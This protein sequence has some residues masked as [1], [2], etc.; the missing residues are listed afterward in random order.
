MT[1]IVQ[2]GVTTFGQGDDIS[3][4]LTFSHPNAG[5]NNRILWCGVNIS[6]SSDVTFTATYAGELLQVGSVQR[7][8]N[9]NLMQ[10]IWTL[11]EQELGFAGPGTHDIVISWT[12]GGTIQ[13]EATIVQLANVQQSGGDSGSFNTEN[14]ASTIATTS[15]AFAGSMSM[16]VVCCQDETESFT[17]NLGQVEIRDNSNFSNFSGAVTLSTHEVLETSN[18][19]STK[20]GATDRMMRE[21]DNRLEEPITISFFAS[22]TTVVSTVSA[23]L[24]IPISATVAAVSDTTIALQRDRGYVTSLGV[25]SG[26]TTNLVRVVTY[27]SLTNSV[28]ALTVQ[29]I[30][31]TAGMAANIAAL[32]TVEGLF[33]ATRPLASVTNVVTVVTAQFGSDFDENKSSLTPGAYVE[34][35]EIDTT[36]IGGSDIFRFITHGYAV[37]DVEWQGQTFTRFPIEIDGFEWNA[38]AQAPPQPTLRL[39]NVNKFVLAAVIGG[40]DLVGAK[41]TRWR[42]YAQFLDNG[43]TPD[44][45]AHFPPD[46]FFIQ[47][48]TIGSK[49]MFEWSLSS[50]LDLPGVRLPKRQILRDE[51][52]GNAYAPGVSQ[53]RFRGR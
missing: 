5:G 18:F 17:H 11:E 48:K 39:S 24:S 12:G 41:V 28:A 9:A 20:T 51:T 14:N 30:M 13:I 34:L 45:N 6:S 22:T 46:I 35:F 43:D 7:L 23:Y 33:G 50:A 2:I 21:M 27:D 49:L 26:V 53:V 19:T 31:R 38:T 1:D 42:T 32:T 52:V 3:S 15:D 44:P 40:G 25:V 29:P 4:P 36:V 10:G 8:G 47:Q 37:S 16:H